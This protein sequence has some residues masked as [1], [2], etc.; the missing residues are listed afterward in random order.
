MSLVLHQFKRAGLAQLAYLVGDS[1]AGVAALID[2]CRD[3]DEY[4]R[5]AKQAGLRITHTVE[6]HIHA[7]FVS[8]TQEMR[9]AVGAE[10]VG[11]K[12][13]D[14]SFELS[15]VSE[16]YSIELGKVR[17]EALHTPGHTPEHLSFLLFDK[18]QG[19]EPIAVFT[20]DTLFNLDVGR[21]DLV[22]SDGGRSNARA[23]YH[24]L[25]DKLLPLGDRV[26]VYPCHGAGSACGKSIGDR[27]QTTIGNEK[28]FNPALK[29][30]SEDDFSD[31]LLDSMPE[32]PFHY[33]R[34]K[35]VNAAP[36]QVKGVCRAPIPP[37]TPRQLEDLSEK[38]DHLILDTRSMLAFGGG[39][40]PGASQYSA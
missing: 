6:T 26:E 35:T 10:I 31:W 40:I 32:P 22:G 25:F 14:Y 17:L 20:G 38:K 30:R 5:V 19:E 39:H 2:P 23:L 34:L 8:G 36:Q 16:G 4:L 12:S 33:K 24:S 9:E 15:Q 18:L 37:L 3:V 13:E 27:D 1:Q 28:K 11:G 29:E 7:D 21:P